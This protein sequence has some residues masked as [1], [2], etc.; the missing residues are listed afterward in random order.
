MIK[1]FADLFM[2]FETK[3]NGSFPGG[4]FLIEGYHTLFRID[5]NGK[6]CGILL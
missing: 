2:I 6:G 5:Q 4:Q 3:L 1:G